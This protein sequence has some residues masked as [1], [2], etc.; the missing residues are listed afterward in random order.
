MFIHVYKIYTN[1]THLTYF[2]CM[3]SLVYIFLKMY[4]VYIYISLC[5][6]VYTYSIDF[7]DSG[8]TSLFVILSIFI[9]VVCLGKICYVGK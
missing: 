3:S 5:V 1:D 7:Y 2:I 4:I 6:C 9:F 8:D